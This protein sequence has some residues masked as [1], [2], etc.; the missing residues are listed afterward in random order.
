MNFKH[1]QYFW[2]VAR[3]GGVLRAAERLHVTPQTISGQL[4]LLEERLGRKLFRKQGR[5]LEL[6]EDGRTA[7]RYADEIFSLGEQLEEALKRGDGGRT[8]EFRVGVADAVPKSLAYRLIEPAARLPEVVRMICR[9]GKIDV[10]L[11]ELAIHR[12]DLVIAN[13]PMPAS[14][15]V[16][17]FNH[18]LGE[19]GVSFFAAPALA[20]QCKGRFPRNLAGMPLLLPGHDSPLAA[21]LQRWL[22]KHALSPRIVGEFDDSALMKAFGQNGQG[23]FVGSAVLEREIREQYGVRVLGRTDEVR[24]EFF[25]ISVERRLRHPCVVAITERARVE[26]LTQGHG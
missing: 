14:F 5:R 15:S 12:L 21:R 6:T 19:S 22:E 16:Q 7:L 9:E 13:V 26:L 4:Q 11:S 10:L 1:L 24:E 17:A 25:A 18:K 3:S 23:L 2:T 8:I 20:R